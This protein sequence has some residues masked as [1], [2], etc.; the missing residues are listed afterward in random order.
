[1]EVI[2]RVC[3]EQPDKPTSLSNIL[4]RLV[5]RIILLK[6]M[7]SFDFTFF[8]LRFS[9]SVNWSEKKNILIEIEFAA[10]RGFSAEIIQL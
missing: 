7:R 1:M 5:E 3:V 9:A 2:T 8:N 4:E 6:R 10:A